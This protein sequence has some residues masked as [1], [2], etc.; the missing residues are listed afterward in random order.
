M[1]DKFTA[2]QISDYLDDPG[3]LPVQIGL[4]VLSSDEVGEHAFS[5]PMPKDVVRVFTTRAAYDDAG[6]NDGDTFVLR[7]SFAEL[8]DALPPASRIDVFAFSCTSGTIAMGLSVLIKTMSAARPNGRFTSPAIGAFEA[9]KFLGIRKISIL[10]PYP[11]GLHSVVC[12]FFGKE[13]MTIKREATFDLQTDTE[14]NR[15]SKKSLFDAAKV[16]TK[17]ADIDALFVSCT[18]LRVV[19][20]IDELENIL[21]VRVL[22]SS[23]VLAWHSLK[24]V[25]YSL[26]IRQYGSLFLKPR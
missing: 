8:F 18:G 11:L 17:G 7:D 20:H 2:T 13:G 26:P 23:Q 1:L 3:R 15:L 10:T 21:G 4:I 25:G 24:L 14:I 12:N 16:L 5:L 19:E 9:F 22:S 6:H